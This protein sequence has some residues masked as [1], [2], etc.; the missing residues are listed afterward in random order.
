MHGGRG[1][2]MTREGGI[3]GEVDKGKK[4]ALSPIM[5]D[6]DQIKRIMATTGKTRNGVPYQYKVNTKTRV[7]VTREG[8]ESDEEE[9]ED[10][11]DVE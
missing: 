10:L 6:E 11:R 7:V 4:E 1:E 5:M 8:L 2:A 9:V 3:E